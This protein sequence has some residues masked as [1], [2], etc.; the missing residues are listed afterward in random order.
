M[1]EALMEYIQSTRATRDNIIQKANILLTSQTQIHRGKAQ[2]KPS[3]TLIKKH[4]RNTSVSVKK[5][6]FPMISNSTSKTTKEF[7]ESKRNPYVSSCPPVR[8]YRPDLKNTRIYRQII[9]TKNLELMTKL[10]NS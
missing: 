7:Y 6:H 2:A 5:G 8:L 9:H 10:Y 1:T 3:K 4:C